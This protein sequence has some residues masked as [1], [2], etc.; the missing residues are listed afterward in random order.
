VSRLYAINHVEGSVDARESDVFN[1]RKS[2]A[3]FRTLASLLYRLL[4]KTFATVAAG[5]PRVPREILH[6]VVR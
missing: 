3:V 1:P 6:F 5:E 4:R 2:L